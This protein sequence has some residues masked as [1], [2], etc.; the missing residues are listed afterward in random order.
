LTVPKSASGSTPL[1]DDGASVI[2]S[3][4]ERDRPLSF[5]VMVWFQPCVLSVRT[6]V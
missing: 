4:D 6:S 3:A 2:T 5:S 1:S